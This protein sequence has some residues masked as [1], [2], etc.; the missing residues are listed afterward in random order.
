MWQCLFSRSNWSHRSYGTTLS[1]GSLG[2]LSGL[3]SE[4]RCLVLGLMI[5]W[6]REEE[7]DF[8]YAEAVMGFSAGP[9]IAADAE[10]VVLAA[11]TICKIHQLLMVSWAV[12]LS[13]STQEEVYAQSEQCPSLL[14]HWLGSGNLVRWPWSFMT[15]NLFLRLSGSLVDIWGLSSSSSLFSQGN[16]LVKSFDQLFELLQFIR[17]AVLLLLFLYLVQDSIN[18]FWIL[19]GLFWTFVVSA[20]C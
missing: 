13:K 3:F 9:A 20:I 4:C 18:F 17:A 12:V 8:L 14:Y 7:S 10:D 19:R 2:A 1:S 6:L 15:T 16:F 11:T 5:V